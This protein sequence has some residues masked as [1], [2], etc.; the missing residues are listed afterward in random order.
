MSNDNTSCFGDGKKMILLCGMY[1][2]FWTDLF[3][4]R[5]FS[6]Q[7]GPVLH[8]AIEYKQYNF[9]ES[10][11]KDDMHMLPNTKRDQAWRY[12]KRSSNYGADQNVYTSVIGTA[13]ECND[14]KALKLITEWNN[15]NNSNKNKKNK[16][17]KKYR[18]NELCVDNFAWCG[19]TAIQFAFIVCDDNFQMLKYLLKKHKPKF[20]NYDIQAVD[21]KDEYLLFKT[22]VKKRDWGDFEE[23]EVTVRDRIKGEITFKPDCEGYTIDERIEMCLQNGKLTQEQCNT[24]LDILKTRRTVL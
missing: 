1:G 8:K 21:E 14:L 17:T 19:N 4:S 16:K 5:F 13:I 15:T 3:V 12:K 18:H 10:F 20:K 23:Y 24:L 9:L 6:Y 2:R 7:Y 11:M 22:I